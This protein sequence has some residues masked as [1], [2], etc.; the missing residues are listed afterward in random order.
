MDASTL[1]SILTFAF[2]PSNP[3]KQVQSNLISFFLR[4]SQISSQRVHRQT[5]ISASKLSRVRYQDEVWL[6]A[7]LGL[8]HR[9]VIGC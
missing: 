8:E 2:F 9:N 1:S 3:K 4:K 6:P 5:V 7:C